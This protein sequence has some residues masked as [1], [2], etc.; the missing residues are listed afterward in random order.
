MPR[1]LIDDPDACIDVLHKMVEKG[2]LGV[3][4]G[5][6][7]GQWYLYGNSVRTLMFQLGSFHVKLLYICPFH[8]AGHA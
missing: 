6:A 5:S 7:F 8:V 4:L 3:K 2:T 1:E